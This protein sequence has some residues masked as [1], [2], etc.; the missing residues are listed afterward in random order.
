[1]HVNAMLSEVCTAA[2]YKQI[3]FAAVTS[4][5]FSLGTMQTA[6]YRSGFAYTSIPKQWYDVSTKVDGNDI[7]IFINLRQT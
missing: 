1:M 4:C 3:R 6:R 7:N 5:Q 2:N